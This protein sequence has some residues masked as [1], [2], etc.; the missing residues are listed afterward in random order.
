MVTRAMLDMYISILSRV[1][2]NA[3]IIYKLS[4]LRNC[5]QIFVQLIIL[6]ADPA[7]HEAILAY[8]TQS[9][10]QPYRR[11]AH[12]KTIENVPSPLLSQ[13]AV[14]FGAFDLARRIA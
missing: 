2:Y 9:T 3:R 7:R 1:Y 4:P 12:R 13:A 14:I 6:L 11:N 10:S 5:G 8:D